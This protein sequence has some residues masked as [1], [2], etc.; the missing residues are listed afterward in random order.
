MISFFSSFHSA[1]K[2]TFGNMV[3][4]FSRLSEGIFY[5]CQ[6]K[7]DDSLLKSFHQTRKHKQKT[8]S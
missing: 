4:N 1:L 7:A 3:F 5:F 2:N 6:N 8:L